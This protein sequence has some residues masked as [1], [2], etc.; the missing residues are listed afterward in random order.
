M[1]CYVASPVES[2]SREHWTTYGVRRASATLYTL[3]T[4]HLRRRDAALHSM[5]AQTTST[6]VYVQ[7]AHVRGLVYSLRCLRFHRVLYVYPFRTRTHTC[8]ENPY[9]HNHNVLSCNYEL[10][11]KKTIPRNYPFLFLF[12]FNSTIKILNFSNANSP[13][14]YKYPN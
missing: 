4:Q 10:S 9:L 13:I 14:D 7:S 5:L 12:Y 3:S 2:T 11:V 6:V 8:C 1:L